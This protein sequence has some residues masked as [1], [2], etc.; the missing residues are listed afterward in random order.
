MSKLFIEEKVHCHFKHLL[1]G[2]F[3]K[4]IACQAPN[5]VVEVASSFS[6]SQSVEASLTSTPPIDASDPP[7][8]QAS[9]IAPQE[10]SPDAPS[11]EYEVVDGTTIYFDGP[12]PTINEAPSLDNVT[13]E[14]ISPTLTQ[15]SPAPATE[16]R[17]AAPEIESSVAEEAR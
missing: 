12:P 15:A 6:Q 14:A 16:A 4:N 3:M 1:Y 2:G 8:P 13:P 11:E 7:Q 9:S 5:P 17:E 10:L